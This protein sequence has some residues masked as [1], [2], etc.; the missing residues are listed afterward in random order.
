MLK[1]S[2]GCRRLS[3][4]SQGDAAAEVDEDRGEAAAAEFELEQRNSGARRKK[5]GG[6]ARRAGL[7]I[8]ASS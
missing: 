3:G 1:R 4:P 7:F 6:K 8:R 2:G 5:G